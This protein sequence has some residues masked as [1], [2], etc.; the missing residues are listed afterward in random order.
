MNESR[1]QHYAAALFSLAAD[2]GKIPEYRQ[3]LQG[4]GALFK[5]NPDFLSFLSSYAIDKPTLFQ[6]IDEQ[7]G[8]SPCRS[9]A[10]FLKVLA[11]Q[12]AISRFPD[13]AS[14]FYSLADEALGI[15]EGIVYSTEALPPELLQAVE[16]A[17]SRR[18]ACQVSLQNR[19]DLGLLGGLKVAVDG[20]VFDGSLEN[21]LEILRKRLLQQEGD[22]L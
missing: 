9:L 2:E 5:D 12:R 11:D 13:V 20:K 18:L 6:S 10:S 16:A 8:S 4:V 19:V 15:K 21:R 7:W 14:A 22:S 17:I 1:C 3:A